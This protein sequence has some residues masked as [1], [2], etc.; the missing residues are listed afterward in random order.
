MEKN[1]PPWTLGQLAQMLQGELC[2]PADKLIEKP[3]NSSS[4]DATGI[5]FAEDED[6]VKKA[7]E[8]GLG[9]VLVAPGVTTAKPSIQ[10]ASPR[11]S[12]GRLLALSVRPLPMNAG[13]HPTAIVDRDA[14]VHETASIGPYAVVERGASIGQNSR[15]F[16]FSYIGEGCTVG[17]DCSIH[18]HVVLYQD[19]TVGNGTVIH[20]GTVVGA[21][22]FGYYWDGSKRVKVP[23]VG[24]V[25]LGDNVEI[26]AL[27]AIDR[28]TAG[29]TSIGDGTKI[30]NFCQIAHNVEI[31]EHTVIAAMAGI[32]GSAKIGS[33]VTMAGGVDLR[34]HVSIVDDVVL[35]GRTGVAQ[36]ITKPGT[37]F[38]IPAMPMT[39]ALRNMVIATRL[40]ELVARL[41]KL[42]RR[43]DSVKK[44]DE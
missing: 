44:G 12:F 17:D 23:Q 35:G 14:R 41:R 10:V 6:H 32:S 2:G 29:T 33:R 28:A 15:I 27:T 3:V 43:V 1:A 11:S 4:Q 18:P 19:V 16:A 13:C 5:A 7:E 9:A 38:G 20:S 30:D 21:D 36:D 26:G 25:Y 31:G 42:E 34:D 22:G 8:S 39:D 37:Y 40:P 24:G